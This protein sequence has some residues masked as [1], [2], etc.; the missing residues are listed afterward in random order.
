[1]VL[2][3]AT[4]DSKAGTSLRAPVVLHEG[5]RH[6]GDRNDYTPQAEAIMRHAQALPWN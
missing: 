1:L 2:I 4:R 6:T 3:R 5:S